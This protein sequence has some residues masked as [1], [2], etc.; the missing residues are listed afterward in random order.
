MRSLLS[1]L[2]PPFQLA[3]EQE[4]LKNGIY[5]E[6]LSQALTL[7]GNGLRPFVMQAMKE[8]YTDRWHQQEPRVRKLA[9]FQQYGSEGPSLD[10]Q[11][12]LKIIDD[13]KYWPAVFQKRLPGIARWQISS[14]RELRNRYAHYDGQDPLFNSREQAEQLIC[15]IKQVLEAIDSKQEVANI[16]RILKEVRRTPI[17]QLKKVLQGEHQASIFVLAGLFFLLVGG[18]RIFNYFRA[19]RVDATRIVVGMPVW[20]IE[21]LRTLEQSLE[22]QLKPSNFW[23]YLRGQTVDIELQTSRNYPI[24]TSRL[25]SREWDVVF[26][27][28]PVVA[29]QALDLGYQPL[30]V[31]FPDSPGYQAVLYS[32]I[33]SPIQSVDDISPKTVVAFGDLFSASKF[34]V[35]WSMLKGRSVT[36]LAGLGDPEI[37]N[38]VKTG[39]ADVGTA[40]DNPETFGLEAQGFRILERSELIPSSIVAL[41]PNLSDNDRTVLKQAMLDLPKSTRSRDQANFAAG[42]PPDYRSLRR[43]INQVR[44]SSACLVLKENQPTSFACPADR[45]KLTQGWIDQAQPRGQSVLLT[46]GAVDGR[47]L[48][49]S[50][51]RSLLNELLDFREASELLNRRVNLALLQGS[52]S[53]QGVYAVQNPNQIEFLD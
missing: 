7:L 35:P 19:P 22:R 46:V 32:R 10:V 11:L 29:V 34:Y 24:A 38:L 42:D 43:M 1:R 5:K 16:E 25:R 41:S 44:A 12:L 40:A 39:A 52:D 51:E 23:S 45:L 9:G 31:M 8:K 15:C 4:A 47:P 50:V 30:G 6:Q 36:L 26:S 18:V 20:D 3:R 14:L 37:K 2:K 13:K 48:S 33:D 27:L 17:Q 53:Q 49:I 21:R 28:S